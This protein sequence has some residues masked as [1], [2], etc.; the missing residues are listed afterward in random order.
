MP[1]SSAPGMVTIAG[2]TARRWGLPDGAKA[3]LTVNFLQSIAKRLTPAVP[4]RD[5]EM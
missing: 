5:W 1:I 3:E 2:L 4:E